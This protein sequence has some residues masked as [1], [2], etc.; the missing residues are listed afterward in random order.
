MRVIVI[1][2][3][4]NQLHYNEEIS[5]KQYRIKGDTGKKVVMRKNV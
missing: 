2:I 1:S 5:E 4:Q 3:W